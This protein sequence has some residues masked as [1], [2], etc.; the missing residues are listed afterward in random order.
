MPARN[1]A[2]RLGALLDALAAQDTPGPVPVVI[3]LNNT[4]DRSREVVAEAGRRHGL[5]L[6]LTLDDHV[7]APAAA[8]AGS[9]R[10]RAMALGL[11]RLGPGS[12]GVLLSTDADTRPPTDWARASLEA[13]SAGAD[14]VGGCL[15]LDELEPLGPEATAMRALWDAYWV[16]VRAIEDAVDPSPYDPPPRHGDHTGASLAITASAYRAAGCVPLVPTGEDRA[17][18]AAA[19]AAG[20]RLVH[21]PSVWTRVSPRLD[22]RAVGGMAQ[23]M[24]RLASST[25]G[26][27]SPLVPA[28][29]HWHARAAWRRDQRDKLGP[30]GLVA[31]EAALPPMIHDTPLTQVCG[32]AMV[33]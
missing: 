27:P 18:V 28:L 24:R 2:D 12:N 10:A 32:P 8:H 19:V 13:I 14:L 1:E 6:A 30:A 17:L 31:A 23:D 33:A 20:A 5:R 29:A 16:Q 11:E 25:G 4:N 15:V 21:P 7:F 3:A 26:G 9:A 22:G